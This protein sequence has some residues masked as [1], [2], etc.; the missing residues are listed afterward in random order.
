[1]LIVTFLTILFSLGV[2][3]ILLAKQKNMLHWLPNY[4]S[5]R[6]NHFT[7]A[8]TVHVLFCFVDHYEPQ[9]KN[10]DNIDLERKRVDRWMSD[11]PAMASQFT[12]AD[13]CHPKHSFFFP[14]EE[15]RHEHLAK[16]SDLCAK[17]YG[18]IE[19]HL[20]HDNDTAEN[21]HKTLTNFAKTL[22]HEHGALPVNS[23]TGQIQY[24]FIHGNW[25][26]DNSDPCGKWCGV[27][28]ELQVLRETGCY[29]DYTFPSAPHPTQPSTIN[30]IYYANDEPTLPKSHDKGVAMQVGGQPSGDLL[31][32]NGPLMLNWKNRK[33]GLMPKIENSDIR[34]SN[35]P[36]KERVDLW[37]KANIHIEG[38][39]EWRFIKIHTHGA[40]DADM[41][42]LLAEP[43]AEMHRYL[44]TKY[45]DGKKYQL[46][47]VS[48]REMFN[49]AKA[50]E[51][52]K[53][54]NPNQYRDFVLAK[55]PFK[56][57]GGV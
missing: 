40:Q 13:G 36:S 52:G 31:L 20:H 49:I 5:Q 38:R 41:D 53:T 55:P 2:V 7:I 43:A 11:Y 30:A 8:E 15:Y 29:V 22:H 17:G 16:L 50:A 1:M 12:D 33:F 6:F 32:I 34:T 24:A 37:V 18:E 45:N 21:L 51:A 4:I 10:K 48:A 14:E 25:A 27:N 23:E 3:L 35:P 28:N 19:I 47:Y 9:W 46:H 44:T 54:G 57:L 39:P 56:H 26:L 42:I